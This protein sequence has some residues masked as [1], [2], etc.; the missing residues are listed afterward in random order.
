[1]PRWLAWFTIGLA[2][3]YYGWDWLPI[4]PHLPPLFHSSSTIV[5]AIYIIVIGLTAVPI[6]LRRLFRR[7]NA[8]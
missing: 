7:G 2:V 8:A 5:K 3:V 1:M 6:L 4:P